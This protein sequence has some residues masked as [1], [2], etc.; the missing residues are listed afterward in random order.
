MDAGNRSVGPHVGWIRQ[1]LSAGDQPDPGRIE[2]LERLTD[3]IRLG[4]PRDHHNRE[5]SDQKR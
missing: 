5:S 2:V 4:H 3:R 1:Q